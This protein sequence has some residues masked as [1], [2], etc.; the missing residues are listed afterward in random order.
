[1]ITKD[2]RKNFIWNTLGAG[3]NAF[4]SPLFLMIVSRVLGIRTAGFF[5]LAFTTS[6]LLSNIGLFNVRSY[7]ITDYNRSH[8]DEVY[9][10]ARIVTSVLM[11]LSVLAYSLTKISDPSLFAVILLLGLWRVPEVLSDVMHGTL[12]MNHR[13]DLAGKSLLLRAVLCIVVFASAVYFARNLILACGLLVCVNVFVLVFYDIRCYRTVCPVH[14][15]HFD[16]LVKDLLR[17][18]FPLFL[19][20]LIYAYLIN[21]PRY[22]IDLFGTPEIQTV[23][24]IIVLPASMIWVVFAMILNPLLPHLS[25]LYFSG[26]KKEFDRK[27]R[28]L[29]LAVTGFGFVYLVFMYLI[30]IRIFEIVYKVPLTPYRLEFMLAGVGSGILCIAAVYSNLLI[31][32]R[33]KRLLLISYIGVTVVS[34]AASVFL[35]IRKGLFGAAVSYLLS[36]FLL[37]GVLITGYIMM[38]RRRK[39]E[40]EG[41]A[42]NR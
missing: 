32:I 2:N 25:E 11:V 35:V 28:S 42:A 22:S 5:T 3:L 17:S 29:I 24:S 4:H 41:P 14:R 23:Y 10:N 7:Q 26:R 1:M 15:M 30:G 27:I 6:L 12:Q 37:M 33:E 19:I 9:L 16:Y 8:S 18:C 40:L 38:D 20:S 21:A 39:S 34:A 31:L 36:M 13:L